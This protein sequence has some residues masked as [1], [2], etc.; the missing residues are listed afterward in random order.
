VNKA[1]N[2]KSCFVLVADSLLVN[3]TG[4]ILAHGECPQA[5]LGMPSSPQPSRGLLVL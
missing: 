3:G 2:G 4:N 1:S 5:G